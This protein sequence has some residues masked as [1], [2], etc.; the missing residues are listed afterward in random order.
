MAHLPSK[1]P[2]DR[3]V[4]AET[5]AARRRPHFT[6]ESEAYA[7]ARMALLAEEIRLRRHAAAVAAQRRALPDGPAIE[8]DYRFID[9]NGNEMGL[10]D[11]FGRHDTLIT[12]FWMYGPDRLR[13][14]PMCTNLLGPL[15]A[16]AA[17]LKE[18]VALAILGRSSV[19][20]QIAFRTERGWHH[21]DFYQMVGDDFVIDTGGLDTGKGWEIPI[22]AVFRKDAEGAVRLFWSDDIGFDMADPGQDPRGPVDLAPLWNLLDLTPG[23]RGTDWYPK[24]TY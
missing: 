9:P 15:D 8:K 10:R 24:L 13:P 17:D 18:R 19:E 4:P 20:R 11:M 14:C 1:H 12:Y 21:L 6:G 7:E 5:M 2:P 16:N 3:L 23:G 22:L